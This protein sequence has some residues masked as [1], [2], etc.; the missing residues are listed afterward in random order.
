MLIVAR[1][2]GWLYGC[3]V[4]DRGRTSPARTAPSTSGTR[5]QCCGGRSTSWMENA[6]LD[7]CP[8]GRASARDGAAVVALSHVD[9]QRPEPPSD[10]EPEGTMPSRAWSTPA[11]R[12]SRRPVRA[13]CRGR[14]VEGVLRR[15]ASRPCRRRGGTTGRGRGSPGSCPHCAGRCFTRFQLQHTWSHVGQPSARC[16]VWSLGM[17]SCATHPQVLGDRHAGGAQVEVALRA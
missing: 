6:V 5:P 17:H 10:W 2:G 16:T 9:R 14:P 12:M 1:N 8:Q 13:P 3:A 4:P 7:P 11:G 15:A